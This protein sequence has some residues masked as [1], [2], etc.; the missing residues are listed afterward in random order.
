MNTLN[1]TR[2]RNSFELTIIEQDENDTVLEVY[3]DHGTREFEGYLYVSHDAVDDAGM[4]NAISDALYNDFVAQ[5]AFA[6]AND[7]AA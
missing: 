4:H 1:Y 2:N 5:K 6:Y 3:S 7:M